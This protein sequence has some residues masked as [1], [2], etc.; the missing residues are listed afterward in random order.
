[1]DNRYEEDFSHLPT[2]SC[3]YSGTMD[4]I[5]PMPVLFGYDSYFAYY[6]AHKKLGYACYAAICPIRDVNVISGFV[7]VSI[8]RTRCNK[9]RVDAIIYSNFT[10]KCHRIVGFLKWI[11]GN[12]TNLAV[13]MSADIF[14]IIRR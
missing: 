14:E 1:M 2:R 11:D 5:E 7:L 4:G 8:L 12:F 13:K 10:K 9:P 3:F 6:C